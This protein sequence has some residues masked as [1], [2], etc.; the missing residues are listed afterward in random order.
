MTTKRRLFAHEYVVDLNGTA[1]AVRAGYSQKRAA[2]EACELLQDP[3]VMALVDKLKAKRMQRLEV[4]AD[5]VL[6][7][8]MEYR[9]A[10][11]RNL[12]DKK[13]GKLLP[14]H[15][16]PEFF[17]RLGVVSLKTREEFET[18]DGKRELVGYV[19]EV[20]WE[21]KT[22]VLELI[23]KHISVNAFREKVEHDV[24]DPL[25][26]LYDQIAGTGLRPADAPGLAGASTPGLGAA[27]QRT[28]PA[29]FRP[30]ED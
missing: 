9:A 24:S 18:K 21:N 6:N 16:W 20:K 3:E 2:V 11:L 22:R 8:L 12:Y 25:K 15:E 14:I 5:M 13:T 1:A 17:T 7:D 23:G 30:V 26:K 28:A 29:A 4:D 19:H 10:D 27:I